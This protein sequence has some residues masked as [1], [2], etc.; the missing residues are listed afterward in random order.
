MIVHA[1]ISSWLATH[2]WKHYVWPSEKHFFLSLSNLETVNSTCL[3]GWSDIINGTNWGSSCRCLVLRLMPT[4]VN[5]AHLKLAHQ[6]LFIRTRLVV[7]TLE[8]SDWEQSIFDFTGYL[9]FEI[10]TSAVFCTWVTPRVFIN[11]F[12]PLSIQ[13]VH[14]I[15][16]MPLPILI[17]TWSILL[18]V[19]LPEVVCLIWL[20]LK[21][22]A[23]GYLFI[24]NN[25]VVGTFET[26]LIA[27]MT[28]VL[29]V[30]SFQTPRCVTY[31]WFH[32][33]AALWGHSSIDHAPSFNTSLSCTKLCRIWPCFFRNVR[34]WCAPVGP[35]LL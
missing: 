33:T 6:F 7:I 29:F 14:S 15:N 35:H 16:S 28:S 17:N 27:V 23:P 9:F 34:L 32:S 2:F 24:M 26:R 8:W 1:R 18:L 20:N 11:I 25:V 3:I 12:K 4:H 19:E 5:I 22:S 30:L 31:L 21:H 13:M 10:Y